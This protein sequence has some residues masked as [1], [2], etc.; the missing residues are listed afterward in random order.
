MDFDT[1]N[2]YIDNNGILKVIFASKIVLECE[3]DFSEC[4]SA[5]KTI[6]LNAA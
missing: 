5:F 1:V 2:N 4:L 6:I 3:N